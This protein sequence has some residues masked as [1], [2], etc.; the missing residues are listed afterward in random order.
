MSWKRKNRVWEGENEK[1]RIREE[2]IGEMIA[3]IQVCNDWINEFVRY[4]EK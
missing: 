3:L 4:V 2:K 1:N